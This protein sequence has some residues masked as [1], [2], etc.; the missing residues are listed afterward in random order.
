MYLHQQAPPFFTFTSRICG[1]GRAACYRGYVV[2]GVGAAFVKQLWA[3]AKGGRGGSRADS[4]PYLQSRNIVIW[5]FKHHGDRPQGLP[6]GGGRHG[7]GERN[8]HPQRGVLLAGKFFNNP[9]NLLFP[10]KVLNRVF[11]ALAHGGDHGL[12]GPPSTPRGAHKGLRERVTQHL[13]PH[14]GGVVRHREAHL[15]VAGVVF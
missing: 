11:H 10:R 14:G 8:P 3:R 4:A 7:G 5:D 15:H 13:G 2:R 6:E 9:D 1:W 12:L